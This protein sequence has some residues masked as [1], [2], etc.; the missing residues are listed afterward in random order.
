MILSV[1]YCQTTTG[2]GQ[3]IGNLVNLWRTTGD[4]Q[5][6]WKSMIGNADRNQALYSIAGPGHWNDPDMLEIG[7]PGL[8]IN[9][10]KVHFSLWAIMA[11]PLLI[12]SNL[13]S[14]PQQS[15]NIY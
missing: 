10:Q 7:N 3:W 14:M 1:E 12:A 2:C 15:I 11:S 5:D 6:N 4:I 9:E 8:T 13:L